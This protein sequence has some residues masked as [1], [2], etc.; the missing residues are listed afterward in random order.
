M[1][2]ILSYCVYI[3]FLSGCDYASYVSTF[4]V[5]YQPKIV[6]GG[7]FAPYKSWNISIKK[8]T[9][10]PSKTVSSQ[11]KSENIPDA[12]V[13]LFENGQFI[14]RLVF[15]VQ[16]EAFYSSKNHLP[17]PG[18]KYKIIVSAIGLPTATAETSVPFQ[19]TVEA[20]NYVFENEVSL[21]NKNG[22]ISFS[23]DDVANQ[24]DFY[25][26]SFFSLDG[27]VSHTLSIK[28]N[29]IIANLDAFDRLSNYDKGQYSCYSCSFSD[30][31]FNGNK[32]EF[33]FGIV[34]LQSSEKTTSRPHKIV[35]RQMGEDLHL[36]LKSQEKQSVSQGD[37]LSGLTV[38]QS[39]VNGGLGVFAAFYSTEYSL[40]ID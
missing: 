8:S 12:E 23:I 11:N 16:K 18:K 25:Q 40:L 21:K 13:Q 2:K 31:F 35:V 14:D 22:S 20:F 3:L 36:F 4:E 24:R 32:H 5:P 29:H 37:P 38:V 28:D 17:L 6:V 33:D 7:I 26:I 30:I 39:N 19:S 9:S 1:K 10:L 27:T 15:D 34:P